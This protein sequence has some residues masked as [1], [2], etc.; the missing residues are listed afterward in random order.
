MWPPSDLKERDSL[1]TL[2]IKLGREDLL[3]AVTFLSVE[4]LGHISGT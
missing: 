4:G 3:K 2:K 1:L